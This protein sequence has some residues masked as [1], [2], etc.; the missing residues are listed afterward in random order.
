MVEIDVLRCSANPSCD[1]IMAGKFTPIFRREESLHIPENCTMYRPRSARARWG[2]SDRCITRPG[3]SLFGR[4]P[5]FGTCLGSH[6]A[7]RCCTTAL[8][9]PCSRFSLEQDM[10]PRKSLGFTTCAIMLRVT[11]ILVL[12]FSMAT[13]YSI[14]KTRLSMCTPGSVVNFSMTYLRCSLAG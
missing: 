7:V 5:V 11:S 3:E 9:S 1:A 2:K 6:R 14:G 4:A 13:S 12:A 8:R 10:T